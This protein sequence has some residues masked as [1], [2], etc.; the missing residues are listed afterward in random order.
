MSV[1]GWKLLTAPKARQVLADLNDIGNRAFSTPSTPRKVSSVVGT[2]V[3]RHSTERQN[4]YPSPLQGFDPTPIRPLQLS[5]RTFAAISGGHNKMRAKSCVDIEY[6]PRFAAC[7]CQDNSS[8]GRQTCKRHSSLRQL[9][10]FSHS[11]LV[12]TRYWSRASW[13]LV[14]VQALPRWLVAMLP[15]ALQL[16]LVQTSCAHN[17]IAAR[18]RNA[19]ALFTRLSGR[20]APSM[21]PG[22]FFFATTA[23]SA[24]V[25]L[26]GDAYV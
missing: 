9:P 25:C 12:V 2:F 3:L 5:W 22:G 8:K 19:R 11:Q 24:P 17:Q 16:A 26:K 7:G 18:S 10:R 1:C 4:R 13:A 6:Q 21:G 14:L 23:G 15:R 20:L